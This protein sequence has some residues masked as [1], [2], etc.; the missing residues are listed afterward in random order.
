MV[1]LVG[2]GR[3]LGHMVIACEGE[4]A[5]EAR[6]SGHVGMLK[7]IGAAINAR[8]F[9]IPDAKDPIELL[10][11]REEVELLG[12]PYGGCSE[13][14]VDAWLKDNVLHSQVGLGGPEGLVVAP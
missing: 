4:H 8:A 11:V 6:G 5:A 13:F 7:D 1:A 9:A 2:C 12:T 10:L 14:F 3:A